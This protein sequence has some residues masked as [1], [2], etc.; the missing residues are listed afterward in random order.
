MSSRAE[1]EP[2]TKPSER[3]RGRVLFISDNKQQQF[4][5][6]LSAR[7]IDVFGVTNGA[8]AMGSLTRTRPHIVVAHA[9]TRNLRVK[10]LAKMLAQSDDGIP[11]ILT[12]SEAST[13]ALR[14]AAIVDGAFDYFTL[15]DELD[16]LVERTQQLVLLRQKMDRLRADADLDSLTGL[17]NRR[18]VRVALRSEEQTSELQSH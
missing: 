13:I 9:S 17:A 2:I 6:A 8:A 16:L 3:A 12:G 18:R 15:P 5:D 7:G 10:E 1:K 4:A 14:Q 11:L